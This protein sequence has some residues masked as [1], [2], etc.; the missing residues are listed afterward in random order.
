MS[1]FLPRHALTNICDVSAQVRAIVDEVMDLVDLTD[2]M[3]DLVGI[4]G[5]VRRRDLVDLMNP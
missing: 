1:P 3:F 4:P 2:I 5:Q